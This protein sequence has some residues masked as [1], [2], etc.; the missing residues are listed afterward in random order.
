[1]LCRDNGD[2]CF[3]GQPKVTDMILVTLTDPLRLDYSTRLHRL[4]GTFKVARGR[5]VEGVSD[6]VYQLEAD[7]LK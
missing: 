7:Y 2:C 4:A 1:V 3:G 6:A 5:T